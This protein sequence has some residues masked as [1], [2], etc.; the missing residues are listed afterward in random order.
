[1]PANFLNFPTE[2]FTILEPPNLGI[3]KFECRQVSRSTDFE[4]LNPTRFFTIF[5]LCDQE[6]HDFYLVKERHTTN[7]K[8]PFFGKG[9][10]GSCDETF[11]DCTMFVDRQIS[12]FWNC[13]KF[14][15]VGFECTSQSLGR[16]VHAT[17]P[18][19]NVVLFARK[20]KL[21]GL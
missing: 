20:G 4:A 16:S 17:R 14:R 9:W 2:R 10:S 6:I 5:E 15:R 13:E 3:D 11:L 7:F 1:M 21:I 8:A 19:E 12:C 18:Q